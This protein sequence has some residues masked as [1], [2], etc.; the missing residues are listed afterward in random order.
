[1]LLELNYG[2]YNLLENLIVKENQEMKNRIKILSFTL[3]L[4]LVLTFAI[5]VLN[6]K[7]EPDKAKDIESVRVELREQVDSGK[8]TK[9]EA[10]VRLAEAQAYLG[11]D[12]KDGKK[13]E[14][15]I[16]PELEALGKELKEQLASGEMSEDEAKAT[17]MEAAKG[18]YGTEKASYSGKESK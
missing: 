15:N 5:V 10:I 18:E 8:L 3:L 2:A 16:S 6:R 1:M 9:E 7:K 14:K 17:W 11:S 4:I 12:K 13:Y